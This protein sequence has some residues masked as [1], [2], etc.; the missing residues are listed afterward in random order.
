MF[1]TE[2]LGYSSPCVRAQPG[3]AYLLPACIAQEEAQAF[4]EHA[5]SHLI[6]RVPE[7]DDFCKGG[8]V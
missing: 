6:W 1:Y 2:K 7:G 3:A 8:A 4:P 5:L